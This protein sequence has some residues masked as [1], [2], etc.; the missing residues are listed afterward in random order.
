MEI[1]DAVLTLSE[2]DA[3]KMEWPLNRSVSRWFLMGMVLFLVVLGGRIFF[4]SV[5]KGEEYSLIALKNSLRALIIPAPRGIMYDITGKPLVQNIPSVDAVLVPA[6]VPTDEGAQAELKR[7][8][9][10]LFGLESEVI[11]NAFAKLDRRSTLPIL[12][13]ERIGQEETLLYLSQ[14]HELPGV[15]LYQTTRRQYLDSLIFSHILGYEGKIR[16]EELEAHPDYLLTD[17]IGKQGIEKSYESALRGKHGW[18]RVEVD[19]FGKV[20]KEL[21]VVQP[22]PGQD[23]ILNIDADLQ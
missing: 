5:I 19:A 8:M 7:R 18:E 13:K 9:A 15:G 10:T 23:L 17:S 1:D 21:G 6:D 3:V 22:V 11:D 2:K 12:L 14:S 16:K 20:K 4:L